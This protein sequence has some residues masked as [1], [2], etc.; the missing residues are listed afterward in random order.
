MS[1]TVRVSSPTHSVLATSCLWRDRAALRRYTPGRDLL[2]QPLIYHAVHICG[3]SC[4][5]KFQV[6]IPSREHVLVAHSV[7][8]LRPFSLLFSDV[9]IVFLLQRPTKH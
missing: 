7:D 4:Y 5:D 3:I 9:A 6:D 8:T 1:K 2:P